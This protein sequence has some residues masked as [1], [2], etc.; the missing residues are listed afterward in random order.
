MLKVPTMDDL[1]MVYIDRGL[2]YLLNERPVSASSIA[3][4][5]CPNARWSVLEVQKSAIPP[6]R[7][8]LVPELM[9]AS[10]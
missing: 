3:A 9:L 6:P 2:M 4:S 5:A 7:E 8:C 1:K 10:H